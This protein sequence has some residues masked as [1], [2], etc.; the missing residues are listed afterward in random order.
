MHEQT[1]R[2]RYSKWQVLFFLIAG[3]VIVG[4]ICVDW[5][6]ATVLIAPR[7]IVEFK[8]PKIRLY[9]DEKPKT[10][11]SALLSIDPQ[12]KIREKQCDPVVNFSVVG[13]GTFNWEAHKIE[14]REDS[15][16]IAGALI[17]S[18]NEGFREV[19]IYPDGSVSYDTRISPYKLTT[20][21]R[22]L[23]IIIKPFIN[24]AESLKD[25]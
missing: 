18:P 16:V 19:L 25:K 14:I 23:G 8:T 21:G 7:T 22:I 2:R 15:L 4:I 20:G 5:K 12:T 10:L 1:V 9:A 11:E 13:T 24:Y 3:T 6:T 17:K